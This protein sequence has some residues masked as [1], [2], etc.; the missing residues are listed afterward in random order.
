MHLTRRG[1]CW[2]AAAWRQI[3][4]CALTLLTGAVVCSPTPAAAMT[5]SSTITVPMTFTATCNLSTTP[6]AFGAYNGA[7]TT[8]TVTITVTC[9]STTPYDNGMDGGAN[10]RCCYTRNMAG[11][12]G[13]L[14]TYDIYR[15]LDH[16]ALG[17]YRRY[18]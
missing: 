17:Q 3:A 2:C 16:P 5:A 14:V 11:P 18:R 12:G 7:A 15:D 10:S 8:S 4:G 9:S 13:V 1:L 6:M